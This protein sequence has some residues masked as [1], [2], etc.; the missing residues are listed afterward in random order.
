[1]G[2]GAPALYQSKK[3]IVEKETREGEREDTPCQSQKHVTFVSTN[4]V[5]E[6][7]QCDETQKILAVGTAGEQLP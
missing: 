3:S 2:A 7:S 6:L 1:M 4:R 5:K